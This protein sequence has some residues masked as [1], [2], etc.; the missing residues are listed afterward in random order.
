MMADA[1]K[2]PA[3]IWLRRGLA[4]VLAA[5]G[6]VLALIALGLALLNIAPV[7]E[8][9]LGAALK[10]ARSGTT[11][12]E[13]GGLD[14]VWPGALRLS[15][16]SI[17]DE[18]GVWLRL[19][20]AELDWR[21]LAL[22]HG[23][24]HITRLDLAGLD[25]M[26][27]PDA[28]EAQA[29]NE[30]FELPELPSLPFALRLERFNAREM[31]LGAAVA[32]E[33][34]D[35][36][37]Q[38]HALLTRR[39]DDVALSVARADGG[40]DHAELRYRFHA[41]PERGLLK[42]SLEEGSAA[43]PS[44]VA[45]LIGLDGVARLA[46]EIDG[47]SLAGLM[48]GAAR[49]DAGRALVLEANAHG[50]LGER[51]NLTFRLNAEGDLVARE[52][53]FLPEARAVAASGRLTQVAAD[54][55]RIEN[56]A[57]AAGGLSVTGEAT[58]TRRAG[59][60][61]VEAAGM[62]DGVEVLFAQP[63][64]A[65]PGP[66]GWRLNGDVDAAL[67][68]ATIREAVLSGLGGEARFAGEARIEL[69]SGAVRAEGDV[70]AA[71]A[72][73]EPLG[74][75]LGQTLRGE[76]EATLSGFTY[77]EGK[78][79]GALALR[80][81]PVGTD[82]E[83]LDRLL[84]Q[85]MTAQ[86]GLRFDDRG[87]WSV[88]ALT[89]VAGGAR[90]DGA[91]TVTAAG[92]REG[93]ASLKI[94]EIAALL[95]GDDTRGAL[96]AQA[97]LGGA[98]GAARLTLKAELSGGAAAGI[99]IATAT[100]EADLVEGGSGPALLVLTGA[101]GR[102]RVATQVTLPTEGGAHFEAIEAQLFGAPL[103][104]AV[105]L[106]PDWIASGEISGR[107]VALAP[108]GRLAGIALEGRGE[109]ALTLNDRAG[110][111]D[112]QATLS[113]RRIDIDIG[114]TLGTGASAGEMLSLDQVEIAAALSDLHG[115]AMLDARLAAGGG[116]SGNTNFSAIAAGAQ[117]PLDNLELT[118]QLDGE[119]LSLRAE[120][121][122]LDIGGRWQGDALSFETLSLTLG[123]T[124]MALA[125]PLRI[126]LPAG[127]LDVAGLALAFAGP[128][129][130]GTLA[131]TMRL[132]PRAVQLTLDAERMPLALLT[133]LLPVDA[134]GG[135]MSGRVRLDTAREEGEVALRFD[136][137]QLTDAE[138][139]QRPAFDATLEGRWAQRRLT[140]AARARGV[141]EEPFVLNASLP[142]VRD[143]GGAWP[144]LPARGAVS[145][146]LGW[147][148]PMESL[149]ALVDLPGQRL[150]GDTEIALQASGDVS[151]PVFSGHA[152]LRGG[153][154][155][156]FATG[157][158]LRDL[159]IRLDGARS[160]VLRF[161]LSGRDGDSGRLTSEGT[162]SL[163]ADRADAIRV[164]T[165]F[166]NLQVARRQDLTLS[167][168]GDLALTGAALPPTKEAP[169][170]LTG[171]L[172]TTDA[173]FIIPERLPFNVPHI[174]VIEVNG[175]DEAAE[176]GPGQEEVP[177]PS[178]LDLALTIG[179][180][181]AQ[182]AGRGVNALWTGDLKVTGTADDPRV[183]GTLRS[184]RGT[185]EFAG[186]TFTLSRGVVTFRG[187]VPPDPAL[188]IALDYS[189]GAFKATIGIGGRSSMPTITLT[190]QPT[191]PQDEIIAR[192]LFEKGVGELSAMEAAQLANT[193]AQLSGA[194]GIGGFGLLG[195]MQR[196]LG[197]DVLR[198]DQG[199]SGGTTVA[200][201]KYLREGFYVGV[202]QGALASDSSVKIEIDLTDN[203]SVDTK[204]G[205]DASSGAGINWKWDY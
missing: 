140:A 135:T 70:A 93:T 113:A 13:I 127:G 182:L 6:L 23:E 21:P 69:A 114:A 18:E 10:A 131:A 175:P 188:D 89:A 150:A 109:I 149:M 58:A 45:R 56:A 160:E 71:F 39:E 46:V 85:G 83:S 133:P 204:V 119:R 189:R 105:R 66:L 72:D 25:L 44:A 92:A 95:A 148:G 156:N 37:A 61:D 55:Y 171:A 196:A 20:S 186:K 111:Q 157:T 129:G 96:T 136:A 183:N 121:V 161:A 32:G 199:A 84:A 115:A 75:L 117:G 30:E 143:P 153:R 80:S 202:E 172:T 53:D 162:I 100:L 116:A 184:L 166:A 33:A 86:A 14:G 63:A 15:D 87:G 1:A 51:A 170:K 28:V 200:A 9:L 152:H 52:L 110:R 176:A 82:D 17:G 178:E 201:G 198:V 174:A 4:V 108:L 11:T 203:I 145:G 50:A 43:R 187:E 168:S 49:I 141:S 190:S 137:V 151:A 169:L 34:I 88:A 19:A 120:T 124:S 36:T 165:K 16:L 77:A 181:P 163:A 60:Y 57:F 76:G 173:L 179:A 65:A 139:D 107:R 7:R 98:P 122:S 191:M 159:D 81:G 79:S 62:A 27:L 48:T 42:L 112:A 118:A 106:S 3:T 67:S 22:W 8:A 74:Q 180:P 12:I 78:G 193:A 26:R 134:T 54:R 142:L 205:Q 164:Q 128:E 167:V 177:F 125:A 97:S 144:A 68:L 94:E 146:D 24:L 40:G 2:N 185:L 103:S 138:L 192:I 101:D 130:A 102:A 123:D 126:A 154:F 195:Q 5:G 35:F 31:Q 73:L 99:D 91:L 104:G 47:Q 38:G 29:G 64:N 90:L 147:R 132:R 194:G 158:A 41:G 197:L 155:E 59:H